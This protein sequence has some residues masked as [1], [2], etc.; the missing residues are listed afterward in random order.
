MAQRL[1][2]NFGV[3]R[4]AKL[5]ALLFELAPNLSEVVDLAVVDEDTKP[6]LGE[7]GLS[8]RLGKID[9]RQPPVA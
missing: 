9:D 6:I 4:A 3:A 8:R 1:K 5:R 2:H 7:H